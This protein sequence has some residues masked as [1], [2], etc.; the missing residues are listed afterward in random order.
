MLLR[1]ACSMIVTS[2]SPLMR[3]DCR[4]W[5]LS[6]TCA[7]TAFTNMGAPQQTWEGSALLAVPCRAA[8]SPPP[9]P[10]QRCTAVCNSQHMCS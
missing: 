8:T 9:P 3:C 6:T 2:G 7:M 1:R 5:L 4:M 10:Y